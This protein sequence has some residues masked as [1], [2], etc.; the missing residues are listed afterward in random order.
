MAD[1]SGGLSGGLSEALETALLAREANAPV[2]VVNGSTIRAGQFAD[3]V[4][5]AAAS[6]PSGRHVIDLSRDR[7]GFVVRFLAVLLRGQVNL[8]LG[9]RDADTLAATRS[10]FPET[11]VITDPATHTGRSA[12]QGSRMAAAVEPERQAAIAFT[13]GTTGAPQPHTKTWRMLATGRLVHWRYLAQWLPTG[14]TPEEIGLV[15]TV[16][17]W[18]MYGLEW[19]LLLPTIAPAVV[20]C[21]D[22]FFPKDV[23]V[24]LDRFTTPTVLITTPTHLRALLKTP[25]PANPVAI[26]LCATSPLDRALSTLAEA[27]LRTRVI[28]LYGCSEIGSLAT[29]RLSHERDWT[30]FDCFDVGVNAGRLTVRADFLPDAVTLPDRFTVADRNRY[31]LE[32]RTTDVVKVGGKRESLA[33]LNA[34]LLRVPGV[35]DG[36]I[37]DPEAVGLPGSGRLAALVVAPGIDARA[38]RSHLVAAMDSAFVPRPIRLVDAL[39]REESSK[40][41]AGRLRKLLATA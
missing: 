28:D 4:A 26:T 27:H 6:L 29:R 38:I 24:A 40:L 19:T 15:A 10:A 14:H 12:A 8:L 31:R 34:I 33:H 16:P 25:R 5:A 2:A 30:F 36:I 32:G 23:K 18:H 7:Y 41:S 17:P 3:D 13:S 11:A 35:T 1:Y 21:D 39:P 20:Y 22:T 9:R 37:Y